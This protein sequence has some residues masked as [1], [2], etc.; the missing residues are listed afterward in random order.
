MSRFPGL[1]S[2]RPELFV[3]YLDVGLGMSIR[4]NL[5]PLVIVLGVG[6]VSG[7]Y[8][9]RP[10]IEDLERQKR[11]EPPERP[12]SAQ[13]AQG[14]PS[15]LRVLE[16]QV[17]NSVVAPKNKDTDSTP[18]IQAVRDEMVRLKEKSPGKSS[19]GLTL[20]SYLQPWDA[21]SR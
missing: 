2:S 21:R 13:A 1:S 20:P 9:F 10:E 3:R 16:E 14:K 4:H 12:P 7:N 18:P 6:L 19:S 11:G 15:E 17:P 8:I 5:L